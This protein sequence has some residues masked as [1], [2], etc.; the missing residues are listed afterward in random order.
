MRLKCK[1]ILALAVAI[2]GPGLAPAQTATVIKNAT[3]ET[4][5]A[6]GRV[7]KA[8]VV[9]RNGK[10]E[11]VGKDVAVP[12]DADVID[13]AGGTL[14]PG[15]IDANFEVAIGPSQGNAGAQTIVLRGRVINI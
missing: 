8:T 9:I 10:I 5:A 15:I 1:A 4:L 13:A 11:A 6:A 3:V 7:E 12:D 2:G 14:M